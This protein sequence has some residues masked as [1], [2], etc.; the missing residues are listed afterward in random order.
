[1]T[2]SNAI[3]ALMQKWSEA[4]D[5]RDLALLGEVLTEDFVLHYPG[6]HRW[7]GDIPGGQAYLDWYDSAI[8]IMDRRETRDVQP[9]AV[10]DTCAVFMLVAR[11]ECAGRALETRRT[12]ICR[13]RD[14]RL[15]EV[16]IHE[17]DPYAVDA[18][19]EHVAAGAAGL[20]P[21]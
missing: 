19:F 5:R 3:E 20:A 10:T 14:G 18:F 4:E 8:R 9:L 7:A 1:M 11:G 12:F 6:R 17:H 15:A 16:W 2:A 13:M 21:R